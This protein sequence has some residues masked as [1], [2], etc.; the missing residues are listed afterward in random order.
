MTS[1]TDR[2]LDLSSFFLADVRD[3]LGPYLSIYLIT[4]HSLSPVSIGLIL[5]IAGFASLTCQPLAGAFVD[6]TGRPRDAITLACILVTV[7]CLSVPFVEYVPL[8]CLLQAMSGAAA[9]VFAPA[10]AALTLGITGAGEG[11]SRRIGRNEMYNHV[12]NGSA[13][14]LA[15]VL[16]AWNGRSVFW[17]MAFNAFCSMICVRMLPRT[18]PA[19]QTV[20]SGDKIDKAKDRKTSSLSLLSSSP[21][22]VFA[23]CLAL[24]HLGNAAMLPLVGQK[25]ASVYGAEYATMLTSCAVVGAQFVMAPVSRLVGAKT[26]TWGRRPLLLIGFA[27]LPV[28][29]LLLSLSSNMYYVLTVQLLDGLGVGIIDTILPLVVRDVVGGTDKSSSFGASLGAIATVQGV[30]AVMSSSLAG[31]VVEY[32]G[33]DVAFRVLGLVACAAWLLLAVKMP[34][35]KCKHKA[36]D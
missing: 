11:F 7:S 29:G 20:T 23:I 31:G 18:T 30:G 28:R 36:I 16:S 19:T 35:T 22:L 3:G 15:G 33:F 24:F 34:E 26:D 25:L 2:W 4:E 10:V 21:L 9:G 27:A 17:L 13:A 6:R 12:G 1:T 5:S 32:A 8:H 14:L